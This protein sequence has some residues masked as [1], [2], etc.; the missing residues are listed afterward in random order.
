[1]KVETSLTVTLTL[2]LTLRPHTKTKAAKE[3][4]CD[5]CDDVLMFQHQWHH[6]SNDKEENK[7]CEFTQWM[8]RQIDRHFIALSKEA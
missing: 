3:K 2:T 5:V 7:N 4:L 8:A 6:L 1:M